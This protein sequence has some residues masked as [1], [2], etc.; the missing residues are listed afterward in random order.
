VRKDPLKDALQKLQEL[1]SQ[2]VSSESIA[3][4]Q[5]VLKKQGGIVVA[6]AADL[7]A[8]WN[9]ESLTTDLV[10]AFERLSKDGL[11][12]DPQ[13]WGKTA[14]IKAMY[15]LAWQD[16]KLFIWGC[17]TMQL[18]P[19]Y[20]GK[21]D[22]AVSLRIVSLQALVQLPVSDT[23]TVMSILADLL[24]DPSHKVRSEAARACI[25][26]QPELVRHLLRLKIRVGDAEPRVLGACFDSLLL[27][28]SSNEAINL[29]LEYTTSEREV[30]QSEALASLA[31]SSLPEAITEVTTLY[32]ALSD[33]QVKRIVLTSLGISSTREAFDFL[34]D[35]LTKGDAHEVKWA[36]TALTSKRHDEER[37]SLIANEV[38]KRNDDVL[39]TIFEK[40]TA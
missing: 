10:G 37:K 23:G 13:C 18:E 33:L 21:Q 38:T 3:A 39:L 30:L 26:C 34:Y 22:S 40:W 8:Q 6:K 15:D 25:Y 35:R 28:D 9:A 32:P 5:A 31:S 4:L 14:I 27:L 24:A 20:G 19:I 16:S 7:A 29:V 36:L 2:E 12:R 1:S 11:K 17:K